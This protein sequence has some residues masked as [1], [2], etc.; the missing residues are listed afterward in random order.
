MWI[1]LD[2]WVEQTPIVKE[3]QWETKICVHWLCI[4]YRRYV[5]LKPFFN[6]KRGIENHSQ[7]IY[8]IMIYGKADIL[9][10]FTQ[11]KN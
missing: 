5:N 3:K 8:S 1:F 9:V 6:Y 7:E 10:I 2:F 11:A 4:W